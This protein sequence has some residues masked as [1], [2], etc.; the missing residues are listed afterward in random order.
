MSGWEELTSESP[1]QYEHIRIYWNIFEYIRIYWNIL[2]SDAVEC[3]FA[4]S[5]LLFVMYNCM[6]I[7][8]C[9]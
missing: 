7:Y 5:L 9:V 1:K 3:F 4:V 6:Y 2:D 8:I